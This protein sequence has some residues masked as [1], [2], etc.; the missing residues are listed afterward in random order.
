MKEIQSNN[1]HK[2]HKWHQKA[3]GIVEYALILAFIVGIGTAIFAKGGLAEAV[4]DAYFQISKTIAYAMDN[5]TAG[6]QRFAQNQLEQGLKN[7]I[8]SGKIKLGNGGWVELDLQTALHPK[9]KQPVNGGADGDVKVNN[10]PGYT[11]FDTLWDAANLKMNQIQ[12]DDADKGNWAG[13][14]IERSG[15]TYNVYYFNGKSAD[16]ATDAPKSTY[17]NTQAMQ[18]LFGNGQAPKTWTP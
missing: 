12:L 14:R 8:T 11:S 6:H 17:K 1:P 4:S 18:N 13:V 3:Q 16:V 9:V 15:D 5:T 10:D 2:L 7:A